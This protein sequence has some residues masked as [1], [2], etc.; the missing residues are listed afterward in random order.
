MVITVLS[1]LTYG[2]QIGARKQRNGDYHSGQDIPWEIMFYL[3]Y[4]NDSSY[5]PP[6]IR[7]KGY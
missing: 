7:L 5:S 1:V 4:A 6:I 2:D 3:F